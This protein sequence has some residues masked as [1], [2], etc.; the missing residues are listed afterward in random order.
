MSE[1]APDLRRKAEEAATIEASDER[2][3]QI[4]ALSQAQCAITMP[5]GGWSPGVALEATMRTYLTILGFLT[6][7]SDQPTEILLQTYAYALDELKASTAATEV[8]YRRLLQGGEDARREM[9]AEGRAF[10]RLLNDAYK[11]R[12]Q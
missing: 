1:Q 8:D 4:T 10:Q 6:R 7:H 9:K 5:E 3:Q 12:I 2:A 11:R